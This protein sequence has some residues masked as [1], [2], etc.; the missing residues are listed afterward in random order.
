MHQSTID[1]LLSTYNGE[2][3]L[4][5]LLDSLLSQTY[6]DF[7]VVV[8]DDGSSDNTIQILE[9][10]I[11]KY[12]D[13]IIQVDKSSSNIGVIKSFERLLKESMS[14]F[15]MFCDQDDV[16]FPDKIE[17]TFSKM[18]EY[19]TQVYNLPILIHTDLCVVDSQMN[20]I[21]NSFWKYSNIN[22]S[23]LLDFNY[24]GV[25]NSV[26]GCTV[27][28][29]KQAVQKALPFPDEVLM[30]DS[31]ISLVVAKYGKIGFLNSPTI[32]YRQHESNEVGAK[33]DKGTCSYV[34]NKIKM[35]RTVFTNNKRQVQLLKKLEYGS[36]AKY[37]FYKI[38]LFLKN[39]V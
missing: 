20:V 8:R 17:K 30:H 39:R 18:K 16:W 26:T 19:E 29:N 12:P 32:Y 24:L 38:L 21:A 27:M 5:F 28:V 10:Y 3:Y 23:F 2:K 35:L 13:F 4:S 36:V 31:W 34:I 33:E 7:K 22:P 11:D 14:Q 25:C 6:K 15:V 1:I 37:G 9:Q